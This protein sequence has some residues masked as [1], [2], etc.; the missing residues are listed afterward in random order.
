MLSYLR[1][2]WLSWRA[3]YLCYDLWRFLMIGIC[4]ISLDFK[5]FFAF[6][7]F[8]DYWLN[9]IL[10]PLLCRMPPSFLR[11]YL[12]EDNILHGGDLSISVL[13]VSYVLYSVSCAGAS[14]HSSLHFFSLIPPVYVSC[15]ILWTLHIGSLMLSSRKMTKHRVRRRTLFWPSHLEPIPT[16]VYRS[17]LDARKSS[18][19]MKIF[20][21]PY[22]WRTNTM[23][24][25]E[26]FTHSPK[27]SGSL[28]VLLEAL[29]L[30][31]ECHTARECID[32][33]YSGY[34]PLEVFETYRPRRDSLI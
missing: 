17:Y 13:L 10:T 14:L 12:S 32:H 18:H 3:P 4:I 15:E 6:W 7:N 30:T 31:H 8:I 33:L 29:V 9:S 2:F 34:T 25:S 24:P 23:I 19:T 28:P 26:H 20:L 22:L 27:T 11:E 1:C 21:Q 5:V 16:Q